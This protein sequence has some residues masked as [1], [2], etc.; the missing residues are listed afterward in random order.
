MT[1][2]EPFQFE[3]EGVVFGIDTPF[4]TK[5]DGFAPGGMSWRTQSQ[6]MPTDGARLFGKDRQAAPTWSWS[7]YTDGEDVES[8]LRHLSQLQKAWR[9][10]RIRERAGEVVEL[11]Y[12]LV[13]GVTRRISGRPGSFSAPMSNLLLNGVAAITAD[14]DCS[15]GLTYSE[16]EESVK[17]TLTAE[18]SDEGFMVHEDGF[19]VP[20]EL[21]AAEGQRTSRIIVGGDEPTWCTITFKGPVYRP[22]LSIDEGV[23]KF[24]LDGTLAYD[25]SATLDTRPWRRTILLDGGASVGGWYRGPKMAKILLEPGAHDLTFTGDDPTN[26]ATCTVTWPTASGSLQ[27]VAG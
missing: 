16:H 2:L 25:R 6:D 15:D 17:L 24:M 27:E 14:F 10:G 9:A 5:D 12:C 19:D 20:I 22:G 4:F 21:A 23:W 3:L 11:R 7:L 13:K 1:D 8:A 26:T 18:T